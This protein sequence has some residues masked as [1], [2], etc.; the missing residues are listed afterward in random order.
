MLSKL[1]MIALLLCVILKYYPKISASMGEVLS[2]QCEY[3]TKELCPACFPEPNNCRFFRE[4]LSFENISFLSRLT[5]RFDQHGVNYAKL[6]RKHKV[7]VKNLNRFKKVESL[8]DVICGQQRT[9]Y[10]GCSLDSDEKYL[11]IMRRKILH[12]DLYEG[13]IICPLG[14]DQALNR[15]LG[16]FDWTDIFKMIL[17]RSN[18]QPLIL[19]LA[20]KQKAPVPNFIFQAGFTLVER[21]DGDV[22]STFYNTPFDTRLLI[23]VELIDA[24]LS[25]NVVYDGF[26]LYLTDLNP[27][28][29]AVEIL[30]NGNIKVSF[31]DLNN[32]I[33]LDSQ[34][35]QINRNNTEIIHTRI[36]CNGCFAYAQEEICSYR[37]NDINLFSICQLFL[38][39]SYGNKQAGFLYTEV[40][41]TEHRRIHQLLHH[42]VYCKPPECQ[43]REKLLLQIQNIIRSLL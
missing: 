30:P 1:Y 42:C 11:S 18:V 6:D 28:N 33:V 10:S 26:R 31:I 15:F 5:T 35:E 21:F 37:Y 8:R 34:S 29:I 41:Q 24:I 7:V 19:K 23:A 25:F 20:G 4:R 3:D 27:D 12:R 38:E 14:N 22:L 9:P 13:A 17:I 32:V 36:D 43:N 39:D 40:D 16:K 2:E